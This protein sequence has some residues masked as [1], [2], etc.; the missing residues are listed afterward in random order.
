[1]ALKTFV[2]INTVN[3]LSDARYCAGMGVDL[4]GF[5][6][7]EEHPDF[8]S[9]ESF[10]EISEWLAG[11]DFVGEFGNTAV[12]TILDKL[13]LYGLKMVETG[14]MKIIDILKGEGYHVILKWRLEEIDLLPS[15]I[16]ADFLLLESSTTPDEGQIVGI[17]EKSGHIKI[18]LAS[19]I[20]EGNVKDLL[21]STNA[22]GIALTA[23]HE[24]RPGYKD[25]DEMA[26]I[27]ELLETE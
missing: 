16:N 2:K 21:Q 8:M 6:L 9:I 27:L 17:K 24:I 25:Y 18:L 23:G 14:N 12:T 13:E 1:M 19:G 11:V 3:N 15:G 7:D 26:D 22:H 20:T 10:R 4:I 5:N